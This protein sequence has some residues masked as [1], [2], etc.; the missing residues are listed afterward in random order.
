MPKELAE[1]LWIK[2]PWRL[3]LKLVRLAQTKFTVSVVAVIFNTENK[4]LLLDH[5][6][7]SAESSWALPGGFI[8]ANEQPEEAI[9]R[10][11]L[12]ESGL[13]IK[14]LSLVFVRTRLK[15]LEI[16]FYAEADG[17]PKPNSFEVRKAEWFSTDNLPSSLSNVQKWLIRKAIQNKKLNLPF[18]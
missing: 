11:I 3:R 1:K 14:N 15:H 13:E 18:Q 12:E 17:L 10:E 5:S 7:R 6:F 9:K 8:Q 2:L 4:I 16:L